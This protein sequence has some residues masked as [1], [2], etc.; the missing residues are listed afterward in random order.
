[1]KF[2]TVVDPHMDTVAPRRRKDDLFETQK[3]K[4]YEIK[5]LCIKHEVT[6]L[7]CTGD[8]FH[9]KESHRVHYRLVNW[10]I[11]FFKEFPVP[12]WGAIGNHDIQATPANWYKQPIGTLVQ[13][14]VIIP[15]WCD[16]TD[17]NPTGFMSYMLDDDI[18]GLMVQISSTIYSYDI[19]KEGHR[20][21]WYRVP[22][23]DHPADFRI[24]VPHGSLVPEG[25]HAPYDHTTPADLAKVI[26]KEELPDLY[27]AGHEHDDLGTYDGP[28]FKVVNYGNL[29]RGSIQEYNLLRDVKV[30]LVTVSKVDGRVTCKLRS[31]KLQSAKPASEVFYTEELKREKLKSEEITQFVEHLK[32]GVQDEFRVLDP[33]ETLRVVNQ[34]Q[35]VSP[36]VE[37]RV[38][39]YVETARNE[40][41]E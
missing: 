3:R 37:A 35:Q 27:V 11:D 22:K 38:T 31:I 14:E 32:A 24:H 12:V 1:M 36:E 18:E 28:G 29:T 30:G 4:W 15:L 5:Q 19:D 33:I 34:A 7:I 20:D 8:W 26:P 17:D 40:L 23:T 2:I 39:H 25:H 6:G 10:M 13:A 9:K 16:A 41:G 21:K